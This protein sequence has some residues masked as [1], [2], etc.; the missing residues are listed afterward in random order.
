MVLV[1]VDAVVTGWSRGEIGLLAGG[2]MLLIA[3]LVVAGLVAWLK[4]SQRLANSNTTNFSY[5]EAIKM[6]LMASAITPFAP[7]PSV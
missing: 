4:V 1:A 3:S 6:D 7:T 5:G 2:V